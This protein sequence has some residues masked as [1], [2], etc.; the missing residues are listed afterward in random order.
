LPGV[1]YIEVSLGRREVLHARSQLFDP[2]PIT[3]SDLS[4]ALHRV[5][6]DVGQI[7][8]DIRHAVAA[9]GRTVVHRFIRVAGENWPNCTVDMIYAAFLNDTHYFIFVESLPAEQQARF[10][11]I[12]G[13]AGL[14]AVMST[15]RVRQLH[16]INGEIA[17]DTEHLVMS[18]SEATFEH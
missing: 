13:F 9:G 17:M 4:S 15:L 10:E 1:S 2:L 5:S 11:W 16:I 7:I 18:F 12:G 14:H 6:S 8:E 3:L